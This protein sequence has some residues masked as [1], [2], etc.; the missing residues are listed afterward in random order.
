MKRRLHLIVMV[1]MAVLLGAGGT[2][3]VTADEA[4]ALPGTVTL[5][6]TSGLITDG[7]MFSQATVSAACPEGHRDKIDIKVA[8]PTGTEGFLAVNITEGA[9]FGSAPFTVRMP[10]GSTPDAGSLKKGLGTSLADGVFPIRIKC[11]PATGTADAE[12]YFA[13]NV[14][15]TG[16]S[17]R[18]KEETVPAVS[19]STSLSAGP[20]KQATIGSTYTLTATVTPDNAVGSVFFSGTDLG[21][22]AAT[23]PVVNGV[24]TLQ[25]SVNSPVRTKSLKATFAPT[26]VTKFEGSVSADVSYAFVDPKSVRARDEEGEAV[27]PSATLEPGQKIRLVVKGFRPEESV[28]VALSGSEAQFTDGTAGADGVLN[29]YEFTVPED[30]ADGN[31]TLSFTGADGGTE[32]DFAFLVGEAG[33]ETEGATEGSTEGSTEGGTEGETEG[34]TE[35]ATEGE[36]E[37]ATEG[38]DAGGAD[39]GGTDSGG[40]DI[41]GT[42]TGGAADGG[43]GG[44][45][46]NPGPLASTGSVG[47]SLGILAALLLVVGGF[48]VYHA[49]RSGRLLSFGPTPRD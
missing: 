18:I 2:V 47:L 7:P 48:V 14:E 35:G 33:G 19:T 26:D 9:P 38:A 17:W 3:I 6:R 34:A 27:E 8:K 49:H 43:T 22:S 31:A 36:T 40:A 24:A 30:A 42:D 41:G 23:V 44:G 10:T 37:G 46:E 5:D 32:V 45:E 28:D 25:A 1:V 15:I 20:V 39:A 16:E 12:N 4:A 11:K 13:F 29:D 21:N